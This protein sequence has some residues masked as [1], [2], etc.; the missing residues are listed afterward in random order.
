MALSGSSDSESIDTPANR[1]TVDSL[2][3]LCASR[4]CMNA[5]VANAASTAAAAQ[6]RNDDV[7]GEAEPLLKASHE[8]GSLTF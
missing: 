6:R 4:L 5:T 7:A 3:S 8:K 1:R 2:A